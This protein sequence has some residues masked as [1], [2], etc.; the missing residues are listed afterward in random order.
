MLLTAGAWVGLVLLVLKFRVVDRRVRRASDAYGPSRR[1]A[2][3]RAASPS[4]SRPA[5]VAAACG[6]RRAAAVAGRRAPAAGFPRTVTDGAGRSLRLADASGA[7]RVA[8]AGERRD[9]VPDGA[10]PSGWSASARCRAIR[11]TATSSPRRRG[12]RRRRSRAA[13][14]IA[15]AEARPDLRHHLQPRRDRAGARVDGRAGLPARQL[16]RSR[17]RDGEHPRRSARRW[18]RRRRP[19]AIDRR[20]AARG[21]RQWRRAGPAGRGRACCRTPAASPPDAAPPSTTSCGAP[22]ASTKR[23]RAA[24]TS[25]RASARSRCWRGIPTCSS[26][27]TCPAKRTACGAGSRRAPASARPPRRAATRSCCIETRRLLAVSQHVVDAVEQLAASLDAFQARAMSLTLP[28]AAVR[29]VLLAL[30][31]AAGR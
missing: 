20:H 10:R 26:P 16:R 14:D 24:S 25:S 22:A 30:L 4:R 7:D 23:P 19:S 8:D 2:A 1:F 28:P 13:E 11:S 15:P 6:R 3:R 5:V 17:R 12:I 21:S 18:A 29:G 9:A 31:V 27:A